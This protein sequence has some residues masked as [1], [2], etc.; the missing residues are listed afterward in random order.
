[1]DFLW[2]ISQPNYW[3]PLLTAALL[4]VPMFILL[5]RLQLRLEGVPL[6]REIAAR[7]G[8]PFVHAA[9]ALGFVLL[10]YPHQF[11]RAGE[12]DFVRNLHAGARPIS[13]LFNLAFVLA[14]F[15][16]WL[17]VLGKYRGMVTSLQITVLGA[18]LLHWRYPEVSMKYFPPASMLL[19]LIALS[20]GSH[21]LAREFGERLGRRLD[22]VFE[23]EGWANLIEAPLD[24]L[25]QGAVLLRYGLYLG[26]QLPG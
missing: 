20:I 24:F 4:H 10:V 7:V 1:M 13:D 21:F 23:T 18:V 16:P 3:L 12:P 8:P 26:G 5:D 17:P 19:G 11:G 22:G 25:L 15:L 14:V 6:S 9:L 2:A